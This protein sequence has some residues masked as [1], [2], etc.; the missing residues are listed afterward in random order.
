MIKYLLR[1]WQLYLWLTNGISDTAKEPDEELWLVKITLSHLANVETQRCPVA[2]QPP[3]ET[4]CS[5]I[6][7][8]FFLYSLGERE[9][10]V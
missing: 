8:A 9:M 4:G 7:C 5:K 10:Q 2:N 1:T 6:H 3:L